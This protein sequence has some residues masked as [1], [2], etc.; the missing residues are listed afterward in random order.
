MSYMLLH[1]ISLSSIIS[2]IDKQ[3]DGYIKVKNLK[4]F[5]LK[6]TQSIYL[7]NEKEIDT[8]LKNMVVGKN[9]EYDTFC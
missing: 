1:N 5:L 3:N 9:V 2:Q 7:V 6:I 8:I 4:D